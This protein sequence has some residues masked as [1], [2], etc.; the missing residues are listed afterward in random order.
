VG[1]A[2]EPGYRRR[3]PGR[4]GDTHALL[5]RAVFRSVSSLDLGR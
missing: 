3:D 1:S 5:V 2:E 4:W